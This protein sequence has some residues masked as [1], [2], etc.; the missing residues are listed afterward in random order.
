M[1]EGVTPLTPTQLSAAEQSAEHPSYL[2]KVIKGL[3]EEGNV[4][5]GGNLGQ[6]LS[7]RIG[8]DAA[9]GEK[10]AEI[11][12]KTLDL[13]ES[14]HSVKAEVADEVQAEEVVKAE[15]SSPDIPKEGSD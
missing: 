8:L 15:E 14:D 6:S 4:I 11:L 12:A 3:D 7:S 9:K 5:T 13:F 1:D 10:A 2:H